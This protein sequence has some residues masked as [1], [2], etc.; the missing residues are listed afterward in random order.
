MNNIGWYRDGYN[1]SYYQN[2]RKKKQGGNVPSSG[3]YMG[4][5][6]VPSSNNQGGANSTSS[7]GAHYYSLT[8]EVLFKRK[9]L[10]SFSYLFEI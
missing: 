6:Q 4:A 3:N 2:T 7:Y 9:Y 5:T 10:N 1:I 8:F